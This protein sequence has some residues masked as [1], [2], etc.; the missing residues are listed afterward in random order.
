[1]TKWEGLICAI[2]TAKTL[3]NA[4]KCALC[5]REATV[6]LRTLIVEEIGSYLSACTRCAVTLVLANTHEPAAPLATRA[7]LKSGRKWHFAA[8]FDGEKWHLTYQY[9]RP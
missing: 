7:V 8:L 1:M 2:K 5:A 9:R 3:A 4:Q 6:R